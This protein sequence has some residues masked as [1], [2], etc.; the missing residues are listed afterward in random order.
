VKKG[1]DFIKVAKETLAEGMPGSENGGDLGY[2]T[3]NR[4]VKPFADTAFAMK[5]GEISKPVQTQ[6][7]WHVIKVEDRR[8]KQAPE[9]A[10]LENR[11]KADIANQT[12][13]ETLENL[14]KTTKTETLLKRDISGDKTDAQDVKKEEKTNEKK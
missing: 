2:F 1:E 3:K 6:F 13:E 11:F 10:S 8:M 4:M 7:G 9:F 5:A 14:K 12:V